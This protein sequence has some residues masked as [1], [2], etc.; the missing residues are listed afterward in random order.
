MCSLSTKALNMAILGIST[1]TRLLGLAIIDQGKLEAYNV[2]LHKSAWSARKAKTIVE[3]LEPCVRQYCITSVVL[4]I[5]YAHHQTKEFRVL[6]SLI[7][8]YFETHQIAV[9]TKDV[10]AFHSLYQTEQKKR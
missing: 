6:I 1:N 10:L 4:S 2:Y 5:P 7:K 9:Y 3:S 8:T